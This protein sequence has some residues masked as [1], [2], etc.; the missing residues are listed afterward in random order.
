VSELT[1]QAWRERPLYW[2][3]IGYVQ[4][5]WATDGVRL[6]IIRRDGMQPDMLRS[7]GAEYNVNRSITREVKKKGAEDANAKAVCDILHEAR[8]HWPADLLGRAK[9]CEDIA[10]R[11]RPFTGEIEKNL[12]SAATKFMWFLEPDGW[13]V[14]DRFA[15]GGMSVAGHLPRLEQLRC[16][17]TRLHEAGFGVLVA[18]VQ[19]FLKLSLLPDLPAARILD[20]LL[21]ARGGRGGNA[22]AIERLNAFLALLR[23][24]TRNPL[25]ALAQD[26]QTRFGGHPLASPDKP[27]VPRRKKARS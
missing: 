22:G 20:T 19:V 9:V 23:A 6:A 27:V 2:S 12:V 24:T 8:R 13:T 3:T 5:W 21:M 26:L 7:L 15:A 18:D 11:M 16:F 10:A 1:C 25:E 4:A 14:F 17:Y